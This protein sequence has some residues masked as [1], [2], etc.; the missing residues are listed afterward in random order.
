MIEHLARINGFIPCTAICNCLVLFISIVTRW[1]HTQT[2][3]LA[4]SEFWTERSGN[5]LQIGTL[6]LL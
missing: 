4:N 5:Q 1:S 3:Q 6:L 2:E